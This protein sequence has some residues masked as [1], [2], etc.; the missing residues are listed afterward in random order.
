MDSK[1]IDEMSIEEKLFAM[2]QLWD[3]LCKDENY[4]LTPD[5]HE[6]VLKERKELIDSGNAKYIT[7]EELKERL[8]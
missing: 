5:W 7:L 4:P 1:V 6:E 2:E 3:S 8:A